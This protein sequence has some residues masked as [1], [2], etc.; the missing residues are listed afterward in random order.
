M[1]DIAKAVRPHIT[2][3]L[4]AKGSISNDELK[5]LITERTGR[6]IVSARTLDIIQEELCEV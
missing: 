1:R 2:P 6:H 5:K 4:E 3:F